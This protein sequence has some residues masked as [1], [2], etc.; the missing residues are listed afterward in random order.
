[1]DEVEIKAIL[2][3]L[4]DLRK[5]YEE[6]KNLHDAQNKI[7]SDIESRLFESEARNA[8]LLSANPDLMFVFD[9]QGYFIDYNGGTNEMYAPPHLFIGKKVD[10]VLPDNI[11]KVTHEKI[12]QLFESGKM[13]VYDYE[14]VINGKL[15]FFESRLVKYGA[16]KALAV[17]RNITQRKNY[18]IALKESQQKYEELYNLLRLMADTTPD[19][20]WAKDLEKRYI[21]A[22][23]A[24]CFELLNAVDT[25]EPI[26]KTDLY[27]ALREREQHPEDPSWHTFGEL[28]MDSDE[29]TMREL[30]P[31]QFDEYGNVKG[32]FIFLDV[33]KAPLFSNEGKLIGVVGTARDITE[34]KEIEEKLKLSEQTYKGII[35]SIS[36]AVYIQDENGV[37]LDVNDTAIRIYGYPRDYFIGRTPEFLSAPGY[38]NLEQVAQCVKKAFNGEPQVFEFWGIRHDK[39][40][41]PKI[42]SLTP[43]MY[44]GKKCVIAVARDITEQ[45]KWEKEILEAKSKAEENDKLKSAFLANMSHEI[46]TPLNGIMGFVQLMRSP[47]LTKD[48]LDKYLNVIERSGERLNELLTGL[49]DMARIEA[50]QVKVI[51]KRTNIESLVHY[52]TEFFTPDVR[53][54]GL[55]ITH[56]ISIPEQLIEVETDGYLLQ[57]IFFNLIKNAIKYTNKGSITIGCE[58]FNSSLLFRVSD[59]GIGVPKDKQKA[60]FERFVRANNDLT[61]PVD[62]AGL[63]LSIAKAYVERLGG[64]IWLESEPGMGSTFYFTVP[65]SPNVNPKSAR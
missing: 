31:M 36:E 54:K 41:F 49:L 57:D 53:A 29:I 28:C 39:T 63:G 50:G 6:L 25:N 34:K 62:G 2:A 46:R 56:E 40:Y 12:N 51:Y 33:H 23:K 45:K 24:M 52:V 10:E 32:K 30:R 3:E 11:A 22:N 1:M 26:G 13:Q 17:V 38:N 61:N 44:F 20:V 42:V 27:F 5:K 47:N 21:F 8:A 59:T 64:K 37:F 7:Q 19:M 65:L 43:G 48:D 14:L 18:E 9:R 15:M 60:I 58:Y 4:D 55:G 35:N 16:D